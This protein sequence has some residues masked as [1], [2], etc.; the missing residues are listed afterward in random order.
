MKNWNTI[1]DVVD[2]E[3]FKQQDIGCP[4][5]FLLKGTQELNVYYFIPVDIKKQIRQIGLEYG[6][7]SRIVKVKRKTIGETDTSS[8]KKKEKK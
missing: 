7:F 3:Y 6:L 1:Y 8:K 5:E 4:K 2:N